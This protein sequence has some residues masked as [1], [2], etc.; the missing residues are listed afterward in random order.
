MKSFVMALTLIFAFAAVPPALEAA[1]ATGSSNTGIG[2]KQTSET[3]MKGKT[4]IHKKQATPSDN[5]TATETR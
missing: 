2:K 1:A 3:Y 5:A 4:S